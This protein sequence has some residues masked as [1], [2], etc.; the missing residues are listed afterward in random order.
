[1]LGPLVVLELCYMRILR[2]NWLKALRRY[3]IVVLEKPVAS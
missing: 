2:A 1:M 3:L